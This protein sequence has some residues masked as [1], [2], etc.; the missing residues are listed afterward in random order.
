MRRLVTSVQ[1]V[2]VGMRDK[3]KEVGALLKRGRS[4]STAPFKGPLPESGSPLA[5]EGPKPDAVAASWNFHEMGGTTID[6]TEPL[7]AVWTA[8]AGVIDSWERS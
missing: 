4:I 1:E 5:A 3:A 2:V 7:P 6:G 8:A